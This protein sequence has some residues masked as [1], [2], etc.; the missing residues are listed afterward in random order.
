[1]HIKKEYLNTSIVSIFLHNLYYYF[2]LK[3]SYIELFISTGVRI[4]KLRR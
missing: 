1:M 4:M 3:N 2:S